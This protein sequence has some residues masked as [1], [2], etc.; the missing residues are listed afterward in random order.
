[1]SASSTE[2]TNLAGKTC[3]ITGGAGGLGRALAAAF[4]RAG[5]N[6]AICDLNEERLKQASAELSGTGA[7]SLLAANADV[8]DPA[9]AQQLF[10]R[11]TAKFRTV[12]VLVNNAAIMDRFDP[13][14]DLD[15]E[16]WDRVISVNLAGPFIFSKL[17]L[18]VMLQQPKPDGCIL[19][20]ASGAAKGG[21]LAG[22][23]DLG[24]ARI[25]RG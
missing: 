24:L 9:A 2:A 23:C 18:R 1:M 3:L 19:N 12:D 25:C 7:G 22:R 21:W 5:A 13:V 20:I 6:V 8:A 17:A 16:L 10:D 11:I 14:A 4:L 15:H